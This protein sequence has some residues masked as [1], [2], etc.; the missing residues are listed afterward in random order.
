MLKSQSLHRPTSACALQSQQYRDAFEQQFM[1]VNKNL[2]AQPTINTK[3]SGSTAITALLQ[4]DRRLLVANVG[5]SRCMLGR[6]SPNGRVSSI[7]LNTD[8]TPDVASEAHRI[9]KCKVS[10]RL[11]LALHVTLDRA[12]R[13][14][15]YIV[16]ESA[17]PHSSR[18][19]L[20]GSSL[21]RPM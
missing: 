17:H 5:D 10:H 4:D 20:V 12:A 13:I 8:H 16:S 14:W 15:P 2:N 18:L 21:R 9:I 11:I 7:A 1:E 6:V 19:P 3:L